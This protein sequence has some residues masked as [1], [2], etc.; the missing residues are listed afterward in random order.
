MT[1][2]THPVPGILQATNSPTQSLM[3]HLY[4]FKYIY[5]YK[6]NPKPKPTNCTLQEVIIAEECY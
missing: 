2:I 3:Q 4:V 6:H 5:F 1:A